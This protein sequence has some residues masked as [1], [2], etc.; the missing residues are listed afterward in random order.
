MPGRVFRPLTAYWWSLAYQQ[1]HRISVVRDK[2]CSN[3]W[4]CKKHHPSSSGTFMISVDTCSALSR[5]DFISQRL[6]NESWNYTWKLKS[7]TWVYKR[8]VVQL[9][10]TS[11]DP[12][13]CSPPGGCVHGILQARILEWV[14]ISFPRWSSHRSH[15]IVFLKT[16]SLQWDA[17]DHNSFLYCKTI[18]SC[19]S[20]LQ[21][22]C[23]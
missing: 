7:F 4:F 21:C 8:S 11:C 23:P 5:Q 1:G 15:V 20:D 6:R 13:D 18:H 2:C 10:P 9:C 19:K 3:T 12:M 14:A 17:N 22:L 16:K